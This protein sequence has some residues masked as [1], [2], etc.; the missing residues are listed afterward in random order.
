MNKL[1]VYKLVLLVLL[2]S[3][4]IVGAHF[5]I[6]LYDY[7]SIE[8]NYN[9]IKAKGCIYF[10]VS[11]IGTLVALYF[12]V[13]LLSKQFRI[14]KNNRVFVFFIP[15]V[16]I[17][18]GAL[19]NE[20]KNKK[21][22]IS[23]NGGIVEQAIVKSKFVGRT[24][25][26]ICVEYNADKE[27]I[28]CKRD[29]Y[30]RLSINDTVL[31]IHSVKFPEMRVVYS[32][33]PDAQMKQQCK[34]GCYYLDGQIFDRFEI[35]KILSIDST[36]AN[37]TDSAVNMA[38]VNQIKKQI[39]YLY[40]EGLLEDTSYYIQTGYIFRKESRGITKPFNTMVYVGIKKNKLWKHEMSMF[41]NIHEGDTILMKI[42]ANNPS[43]NEVVSWHPTPEE[44]EK[45]KK[46]VRLIELD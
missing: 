33:F 31:I 28:K 42:S 5:F 24:C 21:K 30:N 44:M 39:Q 32:F 2:I 43:F 35:E 20:T 7:N 1:N 46:P 9:G 15:F 41:E 4:T 11:L 12:S 16:I 45:Y 19:K 18:V 6:N 14:I 8:S 10:M 23:R 26:Y 38:Y 22:Y 25:R 37:N 3:I 36:N 40:A 17:M 34:D 29:V 27:T 13:Q